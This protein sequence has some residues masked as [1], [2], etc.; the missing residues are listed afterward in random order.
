MTIEKSD[1]T[2]TCS[3]KVSVETGKSLCSLLLYFCCPIG[4]SIGISI[5]IVG[6]KRS[7][8]RKL[9]VS[10]RG[11]RGYSQFH[12]CHQISPTDPHLAF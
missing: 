9:Q 8:G 10:D 4:I 2:V 5:G 3:K 7:A 1:F 12:F 6:Y 11:D